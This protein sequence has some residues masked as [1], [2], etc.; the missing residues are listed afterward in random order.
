MKHLVRT[1]SEKKQA[2]IDAKNTSKFVIGE[3]I[4]VLENTVSS[5]VNKDRATKTCSVK[6]VKVNKLTLTVETTEYRKNEQYKIS[7]K[8][9]LSRDLRNLGA[10][11]FN[12]EYDS[13]RPVAFDLSS[14]LFSLNVLGDKKV[15][16]E[17][18]VINGVKIKEVNWMPYIYDRNGN[19]R[20]YQRE[21]CWTLKD[22]QLLIDSIYNGIDCGKIV[23]RMRSWSTLE[24]M[25]KNGETDVAFRD[26]VDG[27]QRLEA[28]RGFM[29]NEFPDSHGNYYNDLTFLSQNKFT[30]HQLFS[31]AE[32]K[33]DTTDDEVIYQFLRLNFTGVPQSEEHINYVKELNDGLKNYD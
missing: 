9:V 14:I 13:V 10:N 22:K 31:Y 19:K 6:I 23:I 2:L 15:E 21:F 11:P 26:I 4:S 24:V 5:W 28:V 18:Y 30:N 32:M 1:I 8:D 3:N 20:H 33:E 12:K 29:M 17:L 27:K 25:T 7:K 16:D